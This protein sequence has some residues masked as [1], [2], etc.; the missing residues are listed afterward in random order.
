MLTETAT[1]RRVTLATAV[2]R[3]WAWAAV[4]GAH[5]FAL[6]GVLLGMVALAVGATGGDR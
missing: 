4:T 3:S 1:R 2:G 5:A 6:G